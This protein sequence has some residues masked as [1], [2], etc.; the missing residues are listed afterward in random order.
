MA[1]IFLM[2]FFMIVGVLV[3]YTVYIYGFIGIYSSTRD[4]SVNSLIS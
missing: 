4:H 1:S 2:A 3:N